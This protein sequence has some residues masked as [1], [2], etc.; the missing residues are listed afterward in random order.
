MDSGSI[1]SPMLLWKDFKIKYP[2][3]ESKTSEEVFDNVIYSDVYFSGR[4][5]EDGRVRIFGVFAKSRALKKTAKSAGILILP[6]ARESINLEL[7]NLYVKQGYSV[8]MVDYRGETAGVDNY[9]R[10]PKSLSYANY[11]RAANSMDSCAINAKKT[12]WYEWVA[13]AKYALNFL[14]SQRD[15]DSVGVLGIKAGAEIGWQ[16]C[17]TEDSVTC[18]VPLFCSGGR[19]YKGY[20]KNGEQD[21]PMNDDRLRFLAGLD[22]SA[23]AQYLNCPTLFLTAP[24]SVFS[25]AERCIDTFSRVPKITPTYFNFS[26]AYTDVLDFDCKKDVDL[27]F[28][29]YLLS[30][31]ID[32]PK[33]A[34][35]TLNV[36]GGVAVVTVEELDFSV[37]KPKKVTTFLA[38]GVFN[39]SF[40]HWKELKIYS[41]EEGKQVYRHKISSSSSFIT[42]YSVITYRNGLT[43]S[44]KIAFRK[45][46]SIAFPK[47]NLI[48]SGKYGIPSV[49]VSSLSKKSVG[50]IF[51]NG[52]KPYS[53][54]TIAGINGLYC[55][56]G[57]IFNN[58][59]SDFFRLSEYSLLK[60]DVFTEKYCRLTVSLI[61]ENKGSV[62]EYSY[63]VIL[64]PAVVWKDVLIRLSDFKS[65][66]RRSIEDY[67]GIRA[68][69]IYSDVPFAVNNMLVI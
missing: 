41:E 61:V 54:K 17:A 15:L 27:F 40:R 5:V 18:F 47:D 36:E 55:Q 60:F 37:H 25:D 39:P 38:E 10:Y 12:C 42:A 52:E 49:S 2:L 62:G 23:Y 22:A 51:Y 6:D 33:E 43:L 50:G 30:F 57:V 14:K 45:F 68:L 31:K 24:N 8:L 69:K 56:E 16:L 21:L 9:T 63:D 48:Y 29:K 13:V 58:F 65:A 59:N 3:Q 32:F 34:K 19:V 53:V 67:S 66:F 20:Y 64:K 4:E 7:V 46:T 44:T 35:L 28:A 11:E 26:S 1:L